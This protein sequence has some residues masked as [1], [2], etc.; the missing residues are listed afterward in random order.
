MESGSNY[1]S[2]RNNTLVTIKLKKSMISP[3]EIQRGSILCHEGRAKKVKAV[4]ELILFEGE[5]AW[6][7]GSMIEG[8]PLTEEWVMK[9]LFQK[10]DNYFY[11]AD[12]LTSRIISLHPHNESTWIVKIST[13]GNEPMAIRA[14]H[15]VHQLQLTFFGIFREHIKLP[16]IK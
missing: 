4:S 7:G 1:S 6:I 2:V 3:L 16:K 5:K 10:T 13:S 8:E 14:I 9:F 12:P 15:Q 11:W